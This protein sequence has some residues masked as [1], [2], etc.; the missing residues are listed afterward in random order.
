MIALYA[1]AFLL[2]L[3][4]LVLV[5]ELGHYFAARM[6]GVKVLRF[7]IGFGRVM[8][9]RRPG[10]DQTEWAIGLLPLG[11]YVKMLDEREGPV[12][13]SELPRAFNRQ[14]VG[15]RAFIV[16]AGPVANLL[17][18]ILLY[19]LVFMTG[20]TELKPRLG[21][22]PQGSPAAVAGIEAGVTVRAV[23]GKSIASWQDL[24]W[25]VMRQTMNAVALELDGTTSQGIPVVYH[26]NNLRFSLA[27]TEKDPLTPL[28]LL[29]YR[30][31]L[32]AIVGQIMPS[33]AAAIAG[34]QA[35][36]R[37]LE[38]D[39]KTISEWADVA[40]A[41]RNSVGRPLVFTVDR[42]GQ[43]MNLTAIPQLSGESEAR[44][45]R[46]GIAVKEDA[47]AVTEMTTLVR[48]SPGEAA[49]RA[50]AKTWDTAIISL[51]MM[52]R[53]LTGE[54]SWKNLSGPVTIA[55]Y[56]GQTARLGLSYYLSFIALISISLGVL[57]LLPV[58]VLDGGHL[59]YYLA[60]FI[61]GKPLSDRVLA[62]GQQV[63][64]ALLALLMLFAF[65]NDFNRL[66]SG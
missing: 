41:V 38:I 22:P 13:A 24:R 12:A 14:P 39:G 4:L 1:G 53:M 42:A 63:G 43:R 18:A 46:L 55:D 30:P 58:P 33:S 2:A 65:Y 52:G 15:R 45:G 20:I 40:A 32:P 66:F 11:G 3:G 9:S 49:I 7:A 50:V 34:F 27:E 28:G 64:F 60:E 62:I 19:W 17:L 29:L 37:M 47:S 57:N 59:M 21:V 54:L 6:C 23:N 48:Y 25:E 35:D 5:H 26:L 36:D 8:W 51:R 10:S 16:V 44:V 31:R 61:K 56:A